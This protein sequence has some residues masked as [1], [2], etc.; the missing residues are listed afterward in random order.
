M[1]YMKDQTLLFWKKNTQKTPQKTGTFKQLPAAIV[2]VSFRV[3]TQLYFQEYSW[4][5]TVVTTSSIT[6][7][8]L[9]SQSA[10]LLYI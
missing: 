8:F 5:F 1:I 9:S 3:K 6:A 10:V 7:T 4:T 2:N